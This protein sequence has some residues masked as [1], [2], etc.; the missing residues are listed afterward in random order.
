MNKILVKLYV[1][2]I[3]KQ[4]DIMLPLNRRIHNVIILLIKIVKEYSGGVYNPQTM[5]L[6]FD[7]LTARQYDINL[8]IKESNIRNGAKL[9]L[10]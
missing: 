9:I 1:P 8:T 5:P 7:K 4:F 10:I 2:T 3:E 6:L